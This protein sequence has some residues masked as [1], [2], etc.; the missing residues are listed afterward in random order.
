MEAIDRAAYIKNEAIQEI[1]NN[2]ELDRLLIKHFAFT[3]S[4]LKE[5]LYIVLKGSPLNIDSISEILNG[6]EKEMDFEYYRFFDIVCRMKYV[7]CSNKT[8]INHFNNRHSQSY[9]KDTTRLR[10]I[11]LNY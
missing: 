9:F 1:I 3:A 6:L 4:N 7:G 5:L 10:Q 8:I 11:Q 2:K